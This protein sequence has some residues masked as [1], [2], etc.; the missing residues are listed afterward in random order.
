MRQATA[1]V[2]WFEAE[3]NN[4]EGGARHAER[5][6]RDVDHGGTVPRVAASFFVALTS[7]ITTTIWGTYICPSIIFPFT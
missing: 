4:P 2:G 1:A 3:T 7:S 5:G 6:V